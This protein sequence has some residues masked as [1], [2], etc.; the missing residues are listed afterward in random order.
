MNKNKATNPYRKYKFPG[1]HKEEE[2]KL[3]IRKHKIVLLTYALHIII[4]SLLPVIF[5]LFV[6]PQTFSAFLEPPYNNLFILLSVIYYGF[7]WIIIFTA[8]VDYYL[9]IWIITNERL[10]DVEQRG[11][12][13]RVVSELDLKRIQDITSEVHGILPTMFGF[14]NIHIQT[15]AEEKKFELKSIPHPVTVRR[16]I[17]ELYR[18]A[19]EKD[20]LV[21]RER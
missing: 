5:Y 2:I 10:L 14:G 8:W 9:D 16:K 20:R 13:N 4:M 18:A 19:K 11:F 1:Q 6:I 21:F 15:A 7:V 17:T 12:F 3:I